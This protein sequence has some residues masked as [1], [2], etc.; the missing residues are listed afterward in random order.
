[1]TDVS[2]T[3]L[4]RNPEKALVEIKDQLYFRLSFNQEV[5]S[6]MKESE[7]VSSLEPA[8]KYVN[9]EQEFLRNLLDIIERS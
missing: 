5:L 8:I 4:S 1:M 9:N 2:Q 6:T 7:L 3:F